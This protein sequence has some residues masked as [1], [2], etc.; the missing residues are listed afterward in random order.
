MNTVSTGQVIYIIVLFIFQCG[1][2]YANEQIRIAGMGGAFVGLP[3]TESAIF[4]NPASLIS[5]QDNNISVGLFAQ[6]LEYKNLPINDGLQLNTEISFRL[7]PSIYYS[8]AIGKFGLAIGYLYDFNNRSSAI[9]INTTTAEYIV[10]ERKFISDTDTFIN[11]DLFRE[12]ISIFSIGYSV[13]DDLSIGFRFKHRHQILKKGVINRPLVLSA[14]HGPDVNRNDATKLLPAIINNLDIGKSIE[15]FK[16]GKDSVENVEADSSEN[17]FDV[18]IGVQKQ[19]AENIMIGIMLDHLIQHKIV[20]SQPAELRLGISANPIRWLFAGV[21]LHKNLKDKGV[22]F[23]IGYEASYECKKWFKGGVSL[24]NG[25][26]RSTGKNS[27]SIGLGLTLGSSKWSYALVKP[28]DDTPIS[29][30]T[31]I[32]ASTTKF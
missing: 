1:Y 4:G 20:L 13:S 26:S 22:E 9:K 10:D 8:R 32:L 16:N 19:I 18:D 11:Y 29:K 15:D 25:F 21:D 7:N 2:A 14:V 24:Q 31:H 3:N 28:I 27:I 5:V 30:S 12:S 23:N 17:G 6:N